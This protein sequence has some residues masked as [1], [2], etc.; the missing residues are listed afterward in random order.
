MLLNGCP[1]YNPIRDPVHNSIIRIRL[2]Q[3]GSP[4]ELNGGI[5]VLANMKR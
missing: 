1:S 2:G 5:V 4:I 3:K